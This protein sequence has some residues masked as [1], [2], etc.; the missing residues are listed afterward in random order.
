MHACL[1]ALAASKQRPQEYDLDNFVVPCQ[2]MAAGMP[3]RLAIQ[4][5]RRGSGIRQNGKNSPAFTNKRWARVHLYARL[6][7]TSIGDWLVV[8]GTL[9]AFMLIDIY[10]PDQKLSTN[11]ISP[12]VR[13]AILAPVLGWEPLETY[14]WVDA[15]SG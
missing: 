14:L 13:F 9:F 1:A 15:Q 11:F 10:R 6:P 12:A 4:G 2:Q 5:W 3:P 8:T 7:E